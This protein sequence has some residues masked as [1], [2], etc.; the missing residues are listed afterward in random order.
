[1]K[2]KNIVLGLLLGLAILFT[3]YFICDFCLDLSKD[4]S[5]W[6]FG[7]LLG[8]ILL[9][10]TTHFYYSKGKKLISTKLIMFLLVF[11]VVIFIFMSAPSMRFASKVLPSYISFLLGVLAGAIY[12]DRKI[13]KRHLYTS[14]LFLFPFFLNLN[15]YTSWVHFIEFG[16]ISGKVDEQIY[17]PFEVQNI[18]NKILQN[19]SF[20]GKVVVLDFW[21]ISCGPCWVKFPDLQ[22]LYDKYK[23]NPQV[24]IYAVNR[25][26]P[27]D[28]PNQLFEAI[29]EK[30]YTFPV[31]KGTQKVMDDFDI[32]VY[33]TIVVLDQEGN[34]AFMGKI[35]GVEDVIQKLTNE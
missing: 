18:D 28:K 17:V 30:G 26:M 13:Q 35:E 15:F 3:T 21:F 6:G 22:K 31:L 29:E 19:D 9:F 2:I 20:K 16:N 27:K 23:E 7:A 24:E 32:Y 33:P 1:M 4:F 8:F 14:L 25:P 11:A 12:S 34:V 5:L 10:F